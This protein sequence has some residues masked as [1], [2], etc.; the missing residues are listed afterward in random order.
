MV[1]CLRR[2]FPWRS[3]RRAEGEG[4]QAV[5][6]ISDETSRVGGVEWDAKIEKQP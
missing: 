5:W 2:R 4:N 1:S 3:L 6:G